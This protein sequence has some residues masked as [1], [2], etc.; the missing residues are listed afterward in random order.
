MSEKKY[1]PFK[2][3]WPEGPL[4]EV[5]ARRKIM[6]TVREILME[7][8]GIDGEDEITN[9]IIELL[10]ASNEEREIILACNDFELI[11]Q[12]ISKDLK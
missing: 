11:K 4:L 9:Y 5:R 12:L 1:L 8:G 2:P 6:L 7:F 3:D 10:N